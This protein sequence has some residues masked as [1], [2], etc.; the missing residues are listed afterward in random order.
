MHAGIINDSPDKAAAWE[1]YSE[2]LRNLDA[3]EDDLDEFK[4]ELSEVYLLHDEW[5]G[6]AENLLGREQ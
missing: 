2:A 6:I 1:D 3:A 5:M 4:E